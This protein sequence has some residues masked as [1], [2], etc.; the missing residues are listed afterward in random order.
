MAAELEFQAE[1]QVVQ[2]L[3]RPTILMQ[4]MSAN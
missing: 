2:S 1:Q 4:F 3:V